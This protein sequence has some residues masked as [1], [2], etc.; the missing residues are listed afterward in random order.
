MLTLHNMNELK[1]VYNIMR[2]LN[3]KEYTC[4]ISLNLPK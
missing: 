3:V 4:K 2:K 1:S